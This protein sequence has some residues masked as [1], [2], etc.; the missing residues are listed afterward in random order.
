MKTSTVWAWTGK[1]WHA[2][3]RSQT[4][5][6]P[7][8]I[9]CCTTSL[10]LDSEGRS[11]QWASLSSSFISINLKKCTRL[12]EWTHNY[13]ILKIQIFQMSRVQDEELVFLRF[14]R[15]K[16]SSSVQAERQVL[17]IPTDRKEQTGNKLEIILTST[18]YSRYVSFE[19]HS[20]IWN[21][22]GPST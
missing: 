6:Y 12:I 19:F 2:H 16:A 10:S 13:L 4:T 17:H 3:G 15:D 21:D 20:T 14:W 1:T 11:I 18:F 9:L 7:R 5:T 8:H 22:F